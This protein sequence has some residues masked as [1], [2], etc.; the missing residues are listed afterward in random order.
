MTHRDLATDCS[1]RTGLVLDGRRIARV[2]LAAAVACT[3]AP[4]E[5]QPVTSRVLWKVPSSQPATW[6]LNPVANL[7]GEMVYF[8]T[9]DYRLKKITAD[10]AV[11]W[12]V[13][14]GPLQSGPAGWNAVLSGSVVA[15]SKVDLFAYDTTTGAQRWFYR[16]P[17]TD[18]IGFSAIVSDA[19]HIYAASRL[20]RMVSLDATTGV[21]TW[22]VDLSGGETGVGALN[23]TLDDDMVF[24]CTRR[25]FGGPLR[26][27]LWALDAATGQE[28]WHFDFQPERADQP[29]SCF[30]GAVVTQGLVVQPEADGR[31]F[32]FERATGAVRWIAPRV[33]DLPAYLGAPGSLGD[34]RWPAARG[35]DLLVTSTTGIIVSLDPATGRERWRSTP[36]PATIYIRP[37]LDEGTAYVSYGGLYV[38]LDLATGAIRWRDPLRDDYQG[39]ST[40]LSS[41]A[42]I[43]R[44]RVFI[45]GRDGSYALRKP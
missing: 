40:Q 45:G 32:A 5:T 28:R 7:S 41:R 12:D 36:Y 43:G 30:G 4:S 31:V 13:D 27:W 10:G 15:I 11:R 29:S 35:N 44:D 14:I 17:G 26:G 19:A 23:P 3:T 34:Q 24:V 2:A 1:S 8:P 42:V 20:G 9:A 18:D 22:L 21:P 25:A 16:S 39:E 37:V 38:A 6:P 33:H